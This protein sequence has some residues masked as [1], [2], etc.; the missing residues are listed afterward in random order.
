MSLLFG[1]IAFCHLFKIAETD[2]SYVLV[3]QVMLSVACIQ[4]AEN[5]VPASTDGATS[6]PSTPAQLSGPQ[7]V[8][9]VQQHGRHTTV[10][11]I[12]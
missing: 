5:A 10:E 12:T 2:G 3:F 8:L 7:Q 1:M 9:S 6:S 11:G 4:V